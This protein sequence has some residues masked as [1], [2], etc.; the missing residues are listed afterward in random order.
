MDAI[1]RQSKTTICRRLVPSPRLAAILLWFLAVAC[2]AAPPF[3][4]ISAE[5]INHA[6]TS[7]K[8]DG[9]ANSE[10]RKQVLDI[11]QQALSALAA[12]DDRRQKIQELK[13]QA[14][15]APTVLAGLQRQ[16]NGVGKAKTRESVANLDARQLADQLEQLKSKV[17]ELRTQRADL[18]NMLT[19]LAQ[20]PADARNELA[21][22]RKALRQ[23][24]VSPDTAGQS[25]NAIGNAD[26]ALVAARHQALTAKIELLKQELA[27][28]DTREQVFEARRA[29]VQKRLERYTKSLAAVQSAFA[30]QQ[31]NRASQIQE[32]A[33]KRV[34]QLENAP[35]I[36]AQAADKNAD[37]ASELAQITRQ[38][39]AI[40]VTQTRLRDRLEGL[41]NRFNLVRRQ[42]QIGGASAALADVL[43]KQKQLLTEMQLQTLELLRKLP[44]LSAME[45]RAFQ[46]QQKRMQLENSE[47][48]AKQLIAASNK[49]VD[50]SA[51]KTLVDLLEQRQEIINRLASAM[52]RY[53]DAG[54]GLQAMSRQYRQTA[55]SF[56][57]LVNERLFWLPS[58]A[59]I[60][61]SWLPRFVSAVP[62]F[63]SRAHLGNVLSGLFYSVWAW[64]WVAGFGLLLF[65]L[66]MSARGLLR[67][68]LRLAAQ[69]VG[70]VTDDTI[71]VTLR[72]AAASALLCLPWAL[73]LVL[74]GWLLIRTPQT[75]EFVGAVGVALIK[76]GELKLFITSFR[77]VCRPF[78]L[79]QSHFQWPD[80]ARRRL[81]RSLRY[82]LIALMV[83]TFFVGITEVLNDDSLRETIGRVTF[84]FGSLA[85]AWFVWHVL[86]PNRGILSEVFGPE[87][88]GRWLLGYFW[89]PLALGVQ[90]V[91]AALA[92]WGYYYTALQLESRYFVSAGL[93]GGSIIIYSLIIRWVTVAERRLALARALRKREEARDARATR[94]A[95]A[96]AGEGAP[97]SLDSVEIDMVQI[98]EQTR[99]FIRMIVALLAGVALWLIWADLLP[100]LSQLNTISLWQ[101]V[102]TAGDE[103]YIN[104]VTLGAVLLALGVGVLTA[105][106]G[107]NLPGFLE[108]TILRRVS[109][110]AGSR[111]AIAK[112]FQYAIVTVGLLWAISLIGVSWTSIQWLV[113]ALGVGLGFGLQEIFANFVSGLVILFE[114]PVRV[115]DTVSVGALTGTVTRIRIRATTITDWDNKEVIIPNKTFITETVI[116]WTLADAVTRLIVRVSIARDADTDLAEKLITEAIEAESSALEDPAPSVFIVG[117][118]EGQIVFEARVFFYDLYYLLPLQHAL[119]RRIKDAF[120]EHNI[121]ISFPQKD[122]HIRS[123]DESIRQVMAP[124]RARPDGTD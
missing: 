107:R 96:V 11:Y 94:E 88:R 120:A 52:K 124:R 118:E 64:P 49:T 34:R 106:A 41:E 101:H 121:E 83:P 67:S 71:W 54:R 66:L 108:I 110:E 2:V 105:L 32:S 29:L 4:G 10:I 38:N 65:V 43:R 104:K 28:L 97:D 93:L 75:T 98:T 72:A 18:H 100:A 78:G 111:Y 53:V 77:Q 19:S 115:G 31:E 45:L 63:L 57:N 27:T 44:D 36:V 39:E 55:S 13:Q 123:V 73:L 24:E 103:S 76:V 14:E 113:A 102:V 84:I 23:L 59:P 89:M 12:A 90:L 119:Y 82:V 116:N 117:I 46:L 62:D 92:A 122:L 51:Q 22:A 9:Q 99:T 74:A 8:A 79:A 56:G 85:L 48:V 17:A 95:A 26:A 15:Q 81:R 40:A 50:D 47:Q 35:A 61:W 21:S 42:L 68:Q 60:D 1:A 114:R 86:H 33:K 16:L 112:L 7:L 5:S 37:L 3:Q 70:N 80:S 25:A 69:P 6:I 58:F 91:L 20:R 30:E 87:H 109:V